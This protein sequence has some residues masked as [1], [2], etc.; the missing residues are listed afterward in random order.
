M[1]AKFAFD[2]PTSAA[3]N[4]TLATETTDPINQL[5]REQDPN[6]PTDPTFEGLGLQPQEGRF[7]VGLTISLILA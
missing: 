4:P 5:T 6:D 7:R 2:F 3:N 1:L